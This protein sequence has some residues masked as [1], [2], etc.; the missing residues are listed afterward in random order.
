MNRSPLTGR[1]VGSNRVDA[2]VAAAEAERRV[3]AGLDRGRPTSLSDLAG[4]VWPGH[5]MR[6]QG[7]ALAVSPVIR[8]LEV[9]GVVRRA[10]G[11]V[12]WVLA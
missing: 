7:A 2:P 11:G 3:L 1:V 5:R 10:D 4:L 9:R 12:G 8:R 6:P